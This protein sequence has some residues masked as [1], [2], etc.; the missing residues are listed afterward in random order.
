MTLIAA[1]ISKYGI[2]HV[3]A[4]GL[5]RYPGHVT[6]GKRIF[7]LAVGRAALLS[8]TG[9]YDVGG[10]A[11]D[12]WIDDLSADYL[13]TAGTPTLDGFAEFL[14]QALTPQK[15]PLHRRMIHLSGYETDEGE[16]HPVHF[17]IRN[18]R[19]M[20]ADGEYAKPDREFF[21]TEEFWGRD[22]QDAHTKDTI[23]SGGAHLYINGFPGSR[24]SYLVLNQRMLDLYREMWSSSE[25]FHSP[26]SLKELATLLELDMRL[27]LAMLG[28]ADEDH[29]AP[30]ADPEGVAVELIA[31]PADAVDLSPPLKHRVRPTATRGRRHS[32]RAQ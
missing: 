25:R 19:G 16:V 12:R 13:R 30:H 2:I 1:G 20:T 14:R 32:G 3:A 18:F 31:A 26:Q 29:A 4:P 10:T 27:T 7:R 24:L 17:F 28:H 15:N 11:L 8:V 23:K 22:Y 5:T 21:V 9:G 6:A